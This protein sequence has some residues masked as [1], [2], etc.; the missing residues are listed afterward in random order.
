MPNSTYD[1]LIKNANIWTSTPEDPYKIKNFKGDVGVHQG[2]IA[3]IEP[4]INADAD[5]ILDLKGLEL[6]PG[7]I[8][9][10][11]HFR[12]PGLEH[13][14]DLHTGTL[15]AISGGITG[16]FE[17]PNTSP[18]TVTEKDFFHKVSRVKDR[19]HCDVAFYIGAC[20][21][22]ALDLEEL[23]RLPGCSGVKM[24]MGS[25]TGTLLV[26]EQTVLETVVKSG[27]RRFAVHCEDETRLNERKALLD[28]PNV[29]VHDHPKWRDELTALNAT[30]RIIELC[31]KYNRSVHILHVTTA[32]EME[33]LKTKK[34]IC[35]VECTPQ[36][37]TLFA[38]DC[39]DKL[40]T[41]AQMNPPIRTRPHQEGL[42]AGVHN[43]TVDIIGSDHAPHTLAE[44][45]DNQYPKTP[46][47]MTGVQTILPLMLDHVSNGKLSFE[48]LMRLMIINPV[49]LFKVKSR[50]YITV[51]AEATFTAIDLK[52]TR[53]IRN[54]WIKSRSGWTP[55]D[56]IET[57][58][59]P[60]HAIV[61]GQLAM[62]DQEPVGPA[63]GQMLEFEV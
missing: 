12:E 29:S 44:K 18:S 3:A 51:G 37:L 2:K 45:R 57:T 33:F 24:F 42:W 56:G 16:V 50:G 43:G 32:Q 55:F 8:D 30:Q 34:N 58:G 49:Q 41:L 54:D 13:K 36:H 59:W 20:A 46:S 53:T 26:D 62:S 40:G 6:C 60:T 9:T 31:E 17:M 35:S 28:N 1:L 63:Q 47:G 5:E 7:F 11:V 10:Q 27:R 4:S 39:Y 22:N 19:A 23:E 48:H 14:E 25:S 38:P 61:R 52:K 15:G 21:E